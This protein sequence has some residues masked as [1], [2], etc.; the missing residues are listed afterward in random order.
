MA[1]HPQEITAVI[2]LPAMIAEV[3]AA[4]CTISAYKE[5][6][7]STKEALTGLFHQGAPT[8]E[9]MPAQEAR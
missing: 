1:T 2:H 4:N 7:S 9:L 6:L 5:A 3:E 8:D